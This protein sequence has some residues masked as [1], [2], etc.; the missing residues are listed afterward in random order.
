VCA[1]INMNWLGFI[2]KKD[3]SVC[4]NSVFVCV[5]TFYAFHF[6]RT[7]QS[8]L[9]SDTVYFFTFSELVEL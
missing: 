7:A 4:W 1:V 2:N 3:A 8:N 5:Y 6:W 9:C